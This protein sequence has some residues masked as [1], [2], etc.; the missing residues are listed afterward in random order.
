MAF[1]PSGE[2]RLVEGR[3]RQVNSA[4]AGLLNLNML[5]S[6][7]EVVPLRKA[8]TSISVRWVGFRPERL[9]ENSHAVP[10]R[11]RLTAPNPRTK[12]RIQR[13]VEDR[14]GGARKMS[15]SGICPIARSARTMLPSR[16]L[17]QA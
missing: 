12:M 4:N 9:S 15:E 6:G 7:F 8:R 5:E 16:K 1:I 13:F 17:L 2:N 10:R 11:T 3:T 14:L